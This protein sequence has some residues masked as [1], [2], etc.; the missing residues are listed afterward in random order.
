[1]RTILRRIEKGII[2]GHKVDAERGQVWRVLMA[3]TTDTQDKDPADVSATTDHPTAGI[4]DM[5]DSLVDVP[6]ASLELMRTLDMLAE[7]RRKVDQLQAELRKGSNATAPWQARALTAEQTVQ[8]PLPAPNDEPAN[9]T[10]E[11]PP[12]EPDRRPSWRR[13]W[14]G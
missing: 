13:L 3:G 4:T 8:R 10:P 1:M 14:S 5:P 9:V 7:E 12:A 11:K 6:Q 2:K